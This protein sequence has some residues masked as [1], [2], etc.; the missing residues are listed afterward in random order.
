MNNKPLQSKT[1][2]VRIH[3]GN[4]GFAMPLMLCAVVIMLVMG[5]G[6]L[7]FGQHSRRLAVS[8]SSG[9]AAR[10]AADTGL[11]QALYEMNKKVKVLPWNNS[12][13]P[14]L[15]DELLLNTD[16]TYSYAVTGDLS[17]GHFVEST[18]EYG[19]EE[20]TVRCSLPLQGLFEYA[21][22]GDEYVELKNGATV[23]WYNYDF[24][25]KNLQI[26]TNSIIAES[27]VLKDWAT[28]NGDVV[29]GVD[30]NP[31]T[32]I[33]NTGATVTG[34]TY[35]MT[36]EQELPLITVPSWL[37]SLPSGGT[38]NDNITISSSAKYDKI[39]LINSKIITIDGEVSLYIIGDIILKN[40]AELQVVNGDDISLTLYVGGNIEV[41]NSGVINNLNTDPKKLKIY[42]LDGCKS[43]YLKN[44]SDF[45]GA[46]YAPNADVVM[47]NS[48]ETFGAI[49]G[50]SFEQKNSA[51]FNYDASLRDVNIDDEGIHFVITNW[52]E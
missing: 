7:S 6:V 29:V 1:H 19:L 51:A 21:I 47:M 48:G 43:I 31:D 10:C 23:D 52:S 22:F 41:K 50:K 4:R 44:G 17:S 20:K 27:V 18:G 39:D 30:G 33:I 9:I 11:T 32:V 5:V 24:D 8:T 26:G 49:I 34:R 45:Y 2:S 40:S 38:I 3:R 46:I 36:V 12:S 16:A 15:I 37:E 35:A 28:V 42:G 25:D 13:L 14:E